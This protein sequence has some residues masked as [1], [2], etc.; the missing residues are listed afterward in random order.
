MKLLRQLIKWLYSLK[1]AICLLITIAIASAIGT[2][3]PQNESS[4]N[5]LEFYDQN[6]WLGFIDGGKIIF[7]QFDHIYS[8]YWFGFLLIWLG[9]SLIIC[10]WRR[11]WPILKSALK[12]IDYKKPSQIKKLAIAETILISDPEYQLQQLSN[13]L[14]DKGWKIKEQEDRIAGR[15]GVIGRTGPILIHIGMILLMLGA[16]WGY[17]NGQKFEQF[18]TPGS[19]FNLIDNE[20]YDQLKIKLNSFEIERDSAG[21]AEQF[22]S[23]IELHDPKSKSIEIREISVNKPLRYKG[24]TIYQADWRLSSMN[25]K[26]G[27]SP[28]IRLP[29]NNFPELGDEI[30]GL[31][32]PTNIEGENPVLMSV[33]NELGPVKVFDENGI[34]LNNIIPGGSAKNINGITIKITEIVPSSGLLLK[35]DPG[36][37]IVYS[38][39]AI[40]L[41]GGILSIIATK[42]IWAISDKKTNSIYIGGLSNRD[43]IGLANEIPILI[44]E[45]S[46]N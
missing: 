37:P 20:G 31:V 21:R 32:L 15:K 5:Y 43:P 28:E 7:L 3:I 6:P 40:T 25:I 16:M 34:L 13:Y 33:S 27:S 22:I 46:S 35:R 9:A 30:W 14:K 1:V 42:Q 19:S 10:S 23:Q 17:A 8:S 36:V 26:V 18:L 38:G 11:Q 24:A 41:I 45:V 29:L 4:N 44:N 39:F 2:V 12:W